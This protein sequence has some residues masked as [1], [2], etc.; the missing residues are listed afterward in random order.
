MSE[1]YHSEESGDQYDYA[2][3]LRRRE[4]REKSAAM[5]AKSP[6]CE[7][8]G[9]TGRRFALHHRSCEYGQLPWEYPDEAYMIVCNGSCHRKA[10]EDR[11]EQE[12]DAKNYQRYGWQ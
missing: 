6:R 10:D 7:K 12:R 1:N 2:K 4:W 11:E 9:R 5:I 8:C 3:L